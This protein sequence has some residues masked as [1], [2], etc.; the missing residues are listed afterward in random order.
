MPILCEHLHQD[1]TLLDRRLQ[2]HILLLILEVFFKFSF[3]FINILLIS[4]FVSWSRNFQC[5]THLPKQPSYMSYGIGYLKNIKNKFQY[6]F[7]FVGTSV[8]IIHQISFGKR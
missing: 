3:E 1:K 2:Q 4:S 5:K 6:I 7:C 8:T